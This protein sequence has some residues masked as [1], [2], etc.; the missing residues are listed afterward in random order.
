MQQITQSIM[1]VLKCYEKKNEKKRMSCLITYWGPVWQPG[2]VC[3]VQ[4]D[5]T[6]QHDMF[7]RV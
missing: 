5:C 1:Y 7:D 3:T 6:V 2:W 4:C